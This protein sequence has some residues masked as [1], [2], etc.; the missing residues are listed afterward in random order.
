MGAVEKGAAAAENIDVEVDAG[1]GRGAVA[2]LGAEVGKDAATEKDVASEKDAAAEKGA[3]AEK[4]AAAGRVVETG[5]DA[6]TESDAAVERSVAFASGA[7]DAA[8]EAPGSVGAGFSERQFEVSRQEATWLASGLERWARAWQ[9]RCLCV[10]A[11]WLMQSLG[12]D[13]T[14]RLTAEEKMI[15]KQG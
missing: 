8:E 13:V 1:V 15:G 11:L 12:H 14:R 2:E 3:V 5:K 7:V 6:A 9:E 10:P 4:G